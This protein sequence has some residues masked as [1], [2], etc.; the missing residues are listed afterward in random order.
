VPIA[1]SQATVEG[2]R[3]IAENLTGRRNRIGT[4]RVQRVDRPG[5]PPQDGDAAARGPADNGHVD[6]A[7]GARSGASRLD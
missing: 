7:D 2:L 3:L 4:V 1:G 6:S 5:E